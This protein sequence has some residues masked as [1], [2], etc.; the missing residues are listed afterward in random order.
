MRVAILPEHLFNHPEIGVDEIAVM[1]ALSLHADRSGSCFPSQ[2]LLARILGKSRPWVCAVIGKL[3][4]LGLL[5]KQ[6]RYR[7]DG[8]ERSCLYKLVIAQTKVEPDSP[9]EC[10]PESSAYPSTD[11]DCLDSDTA[12]HAADSIKNPKD[13]RDETPPA[14]AHEEAD[15]RIIQSVVHLPNHCAPVD[16]PNPDDSNKAFRNAISIPSIPSKDWQPTDEDLIYALERFPSADLTEHTE[17]FVTKSR[18]KGYRYHDLSAAWRTWLVEDES[19]RAS[20]MNRFTGSRAKHSAAQMKFN[21]WASVAHQ[22]SQE[23]RRAA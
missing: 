2:A 9:T 7:H 19:A 17:K 13:Q 11:R 18:A 16:D 10:T 3:V 22:A 4:E 1:A 5:E 20:G 14:C 23:V 15:D 8:G 12:C 6:H 21:V